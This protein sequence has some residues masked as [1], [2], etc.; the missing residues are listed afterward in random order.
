MHKNN[1][2]RLLV[3]P[4]FSSGLLTVTLSAAA[5]VVAT[6]SYFAGNGL[7]YDYLFGPHSSTELIRQSKGTISALNNTVFG[8]SVLN[9][10]LYFG[11]WMLVGLVVYILLYSLLKGTAAAAEDIQETTYKNMR[12]REMLTNLG[13]RL[14][15]RAA[16][17]IAWALYWVVF[18]KIL[19]PFS[20]LSARV[21][22]G[23]LPAPSGWLYGLLGLVVLILSTHIHLILLRL[24]TLRSRLFDSA[25]LSSQ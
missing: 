12:F 16:A 20:V 14:A 1:R 9:K 19:L 17:L 11:F 7:V 15:V 25:E 3:I 8:N 10:I 2:F 21:G 5:L 18:I 22:G 6:V 13:T 4:S 24:V 23:D